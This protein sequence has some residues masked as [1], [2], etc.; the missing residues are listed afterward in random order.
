MNVLQMFR[1]SVNFIKRTGIPGFIPG[2]VGDST[3]QHFPEDAGTGPAT[4][5]LF[6]KFIPIPIQ[7]NQINP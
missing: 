1:M 7:Q 6:I 3:F 5:L 4:Y 2:S